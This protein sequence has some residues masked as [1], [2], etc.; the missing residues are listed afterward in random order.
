MADEEKKR[1]ELYCFVSDR[2]CGA[3]C[4]AYLTEPPKGEDYAAGEPWTHCLLLVNAQRVGKHLVVLASQGRDL[5]KHNHVK[6]A[7]DARAKANAVPIP[8]VR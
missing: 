1:D 8:P 2:L 5:L 7:D 6:S 4:V 3:D